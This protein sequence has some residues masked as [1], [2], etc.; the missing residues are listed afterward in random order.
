MVDKRGTVDKKR[1]SGPVWALKQLE[2][3]VLKRF[4]DDLRN[5]EDEGFGDERFCKNVQGAIRSAGEAFPSADT[6]VFILRDLFLR[7]YLELYIKWNEIR[8][9]GDGAATE[10]KKLHRL[11]SGV[12]K[13]FARLRKQYSNAIHLVI[14]NEKVDQMILAFGALEENHPKK[15]PAM[16]AGLNKYRGARRRAWNRRKPESRE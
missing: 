14:T 10:R 11:L 9:K 12:I 15:L 16:R 1:R 4:H 6:R 8:G 5:Y 2:R 13:D 7:E 3:Q